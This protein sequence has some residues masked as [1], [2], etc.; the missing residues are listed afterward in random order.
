M[1]C[2]VT[3]GKRFTINTG[4]F[5]SVQPNCSITLKDVDI[6]NVVDV[7]ALLETVVD[8]L[9]HIQMKT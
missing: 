1:K 7:H 8:G 6:D 3:I 4:D 9:F 2:D 5:S